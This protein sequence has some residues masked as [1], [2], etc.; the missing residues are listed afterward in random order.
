MPSA[1]ALPGK[2]AVLPGE[3]E[4]FDRLLDHLAREHG[5]VTLS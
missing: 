1:I 2:P 5:P 4:R 3:S